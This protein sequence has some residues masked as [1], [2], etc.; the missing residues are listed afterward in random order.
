MATQHIRFSKRIFIV[1][2]CI[3]TL[4][5]AFTAV[6]AQNISE[7]PNLFGTADSEGAQISGTEST[8]VPA[9]A[10][11]TA[12]VRSRIVS[13]DF[14]LLKANDSAKDAVPSFQLNLFDDASYTCM[15]SQKTVNPDGTISLTGTTE[16][17]D[18]SSVFITYSQTE[19]VLIGTIFRKDGVYDIKYLSDGRYA[20]RQIDQSKFNEHP[21]S[22][23][24]GGVEKGTVSPESDSM[25]DAAKSITKSTS[26]GAEIDILVAYTPKAMTQVG[27]EA[28]INVLANN[29]IAVSNAAYAKVGITQRLRLKYTIETTTMVAD[30]SANNWEKVLS[31]LINTT[32]GVLDEVSDARE[33]YKADLVVLLAGS[34][35]SCGLA[36]NIDVSKTPSEGYAVMAHDCAVDNLSFPHELGHLMGGKHDWYMYLNEEHGH[37]GWDKEAKDDHAHGFIASD[38]SFRTIMSYVNQC[39]YEGGVSCPRLPFF[40][41]STYI[42]NGTAA[43]IDSGDYK[44]ANVWLTL[45]STADAISN[46]YT[47]PVETPLTVTASLTGP[48]S[49]KVSWDTVTVPGATSV[50]YELY[51]SNYVMGAKALPGDYTKIYSGTDTSYTVTGLTE[52]ATYYFRVVT[53]AVINGVSTSSTSY[54][55]IATAAVPMLSTAPIAVITEASGSYIKVSWSG[56]A[57]V[58][59]FQLYS[60]ESADGTFGLEWEGSGTSHTVSG[61]TLGK[62]YYFKVRSSMTINGTLYNSDYSNVVSA[63]TFSPKPPESIS[64]SS[65]SKGFTVFWSAADGAESYRI[66]YSLSADGTFESI[67]TETALFHK[68]TTTSTVVFYAKVY[69]IQTI[70]GIKYV[71]DSSPLA[72]SAMITDTAEPQNFKLTRGKGIV[73]S[74]WDK[75]SD[76][77]RYKLE[78]STAINGTYSALYEGTDTSHISNIDDS[79]AALFFKLY[80]VTIKDSKEVLSDPATGAIV[81]MPADTELSAIFPIYTWGNGPAMGPGPDTRGIPQTGFSAK[82][83]TVLPMQ[84]QAMEY[85]KTGFTLEIPSIESKSDLVEVPIVNGAQDVSWL[86][87]EAG[88]ISENPE[89]GIRLIAAHNHLNNMSAGPFAFL[90]QLSENDRVFLRNTDGNLVQ[91]QVTANLKKTPEEI[92]TDKTAVADGSLVLVTC[93]DELAEGGYQNRRIVIASPIG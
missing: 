31:Y 83:I 89:N 40:A 48:T 62:T 91:Y 33:T 14:S 86:G 58:D 93:E 42:Y 52:G 60:S 34:T 27:G 81:P 44:Q 29:A 41:N 23:P 75:V 15:I 24:E 63:K 70:D 17:D 32:D 74:S 36:A 77:V 84:P 72:A 1:L 71:S 19:D 90:S 8:S 9:E 35:D 45:N 80:S 54:S 6:Q 76:A 85:H 65:N 25:D 18:S 49:A 57:N 16:D 38:Y 79:A 13:I 47:D 73:I 56:A 64:I 59:N 61:L 67:T 21:E 78:Y 2:M 22:N 69:S 28:A 51:M 53:V 30:E 39:N 88:L 50:S 3:L 46:F 11:G 55:G 26:S 12:V 10:A 87:N 68:F 82:H 4:S 5:I 37:G 66:L 43:G 7:A 92:L 20:V